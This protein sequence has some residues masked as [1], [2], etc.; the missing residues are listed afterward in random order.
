MV[1]LTNARSVQDEKLVEAAFQ[2]H[3]SPESRAA[4]APVYG[5]TTTN[6]IVDARPTTNA[7]ANTAKGAGTENM[8]HYK[9]CKKVYL[10]IDHIHAMRESLARV[11]E[12]LR[13][14]EAL[15]ASVNGD[16]PGSA[17]LIPVDRQAL[18][19]FALLHV[20][21]LSFIFKSVAA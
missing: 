6:L 4:T 13:E 20:R 2:S 7:M 17:P 1:G 11:V 16:V 10:G 14:T 21:G 12:V 19:P 5:A 9:D 3:F 8:D 18:R 15:S